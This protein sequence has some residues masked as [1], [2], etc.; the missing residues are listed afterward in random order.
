MYLVFFFEDI[1]IIIVGFLFFVCRN[2]REFI[3]VVIVFLNF[4]V[5]VGNVVCIDAVNSRL[6]ELESILRIF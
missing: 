6:L 1:L 2:W 5:F 4:L 3:E